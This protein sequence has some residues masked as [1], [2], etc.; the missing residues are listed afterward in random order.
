MSIRL[1][2]TRLKE[3]ERDIARHVQALENVHELKDIREYKMRHTQ[4]K[5]L[6]SLRDFNKVLLKSLMSGDAESDWIQ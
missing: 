2:E 6:R 5:Q 4:L 3:I 1:V